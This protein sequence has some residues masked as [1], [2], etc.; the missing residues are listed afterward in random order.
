[1]AYVDSLTGLPNRMAFE[2]RLYELMEEQKEKSHAILFIDID[3]F[4]NI[5]YNFV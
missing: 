2:E 5:S 4:K 1:M 3:N